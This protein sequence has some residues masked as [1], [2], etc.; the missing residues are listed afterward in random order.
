M[1]S[2][3][4]QH[5]DWRDEL[6]KARRALVLAAL[7]LS[8]CG[9]A[10]LESIGLRSSDW[11]NEPTVPTTVAVV[12]TTPT[13]I[14]VERLLW[15][16]DGIE[17]PV[18]ADDIA[19]ILAEVFRRR[20]GDRFIQASRSEIVAALPDVGFPG[21]AP[22]AAEWVSSQL[23]FNNDGAVADDPSAAFGIWS[24]EPYTR[25]RSVAQ[26]IVL[27]VS[28]DPEAAAE[29]AS[30]VV[31]SCAR[32]SER[33]TEE[34]EIIS[35]GERD[36]WLLN[37]ASGSTLIWFQ[38]TYRYELFGRSFVPFEILRGMSGDMVPLALIGAESS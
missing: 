30:G 34:C 11:I 22:A 31:P 16:N 8:A 18:P 25:S 36:T 17:N 9:E 27:R 23:V 10:P 26:M 12:T 29:L 19:G 28:I 37:A 33:T 15:S 35:V 6:V 4:R 13:V 1:T 14:P 5:S 3:E 20:Q 7:V 38:G 21:R 24:A 2:S 32:F